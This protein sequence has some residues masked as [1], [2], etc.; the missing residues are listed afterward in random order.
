MPLFSCFF[1]SEPSAF[2]YR[3][4]EKVIFVSLLKNTQMQDPPAFGEAVS[5]RQTK[6]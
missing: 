2:R 3:F 1:A 6:S 5:R 4:A